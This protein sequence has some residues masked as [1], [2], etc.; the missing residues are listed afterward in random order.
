MSS[1]KDE[2]REI[3]PS[4]LQKEQQQAVNKALD[5]TRDDIRKSV[6][7]AKREIPR[8]TEAVN[9]YQEQTIQ[10]ARE[11]ADN[12]IE[13]QKEIINSFQSAW[14]PYLENYTRNWNTVFSPGRVSEVYAN[15]VRSYADNLVSVTR[16]TNN[17]IFGN[18]EAFSTSL[19]QA[20]DNAKELS[21]I[22]VNAAKTF[23]QASTE[24]AR[25]A[26]H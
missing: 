9:E 6:N 8:Y 22:G 16:L 11:I 18:V 25:L 14:T 5:Q 12:F 20:K 26:H 13:S 3:T 19:Q 7:E 10:A 24:T 4:Q 21:R 17:V 2:A 1:K 15:A 23:E